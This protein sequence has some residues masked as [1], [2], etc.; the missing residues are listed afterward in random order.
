MN[1]R[2]CATSA[3]TRR[4]ILANSILI[5]QLY[6]TARMTKAI[7]SVRSAGG[8]HAQDAAELGRPP[9][10]IAQPSLEWNHGLAQLADRQHRRIKQNAVCAVCVRLRGHMGSTARKL[11]GTGLAF[12]IS[13]RTRT[14]KRVEVRWAQRQ[15]GIPCCCSTRSI[16]E[17]D[18][19]A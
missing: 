3:H 16:Q 19:C 15:M 14:A 12:A 18:C 2:Q 9:P 17:R 6:I 5:S 7:S 11:I 1:T 13:V 10:D 4:A 8:L